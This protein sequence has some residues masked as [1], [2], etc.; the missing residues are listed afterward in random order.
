[1]I[2]LISS[3]FSLETES[4]AW[5]KE[6]NK[7]ENN[8]VVNK[9]LERNTLPT[10]FLITPNV[11]DRGVRRDGDDDDTSIDVSDDDNSNDDSAAAVNTAC[12]D[13][14]NDNPNADVAVGFD[15]DGDSADDDADALAVDIASD[16]AVDD[17]P[18]AD[19]DADVA[20]GFDDDSNSVDRHADASAG[21]IAADGECDEDDSNGEGEINDKGD[22][23]IDCN[24]AECWRKLNCQN[25]I[26][27]LVGRNEFWNKIF[28]ISFFRILNTFFV[29]QKRLS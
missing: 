4:F 19:A 12:D 17:D 11:D 22:C 24:K 21:N 25:K 10:R 13:A 8:D 1:M 5:D 20:A 28:S 27:I 23:D 7:V 15:D 3:P 14:A 6:E 9:K 2:L 18:E 29:K 26:D 16:D